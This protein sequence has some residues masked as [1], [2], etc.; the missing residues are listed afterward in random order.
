MRKNKRD[1]LGDRRCHLSPV[2][3]SVRAAEQPF[4]SCGIDVFRLFGIIGNATS[5]ASESAGVL[6]KAK[7]IHD[8]PNA[9]GRCSE[10]PAGLH[11]SRHVGMDQL[12]KT[13]PRTAIHHPPAFAGILASIDALLLY[14]GVHGIRL[15]GV[16]RN[17]DLVAAGKS[18]GQ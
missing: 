12:D 2:L 13:I 10:E 11:A 8:A 17:R 15:R 16:G 5:L 6:P 18:L 1:R 3:S 14:D 4:L 9:A 7:T